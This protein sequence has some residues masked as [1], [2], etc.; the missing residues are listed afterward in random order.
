M[1]VRAIVLKNL[2]VTVVESSPVPFPE[3]VTDEMMIDEFWLDSLAFA[4]L[5]VRI[6]ADLGCLPLTF[7]DG[8][9]FP[10]TVGE[11]VHSY[12]QKLVVSE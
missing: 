4:N 7:F 10:R 9:D 1:D 2:A 11:L 5:M 6:E 3:D 8:T 12:Q